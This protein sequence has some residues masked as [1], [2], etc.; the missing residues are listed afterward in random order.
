MINTRIQGTVTINNRKG[1]KIF[2]WDF[3]MT[4]LWK[5]TVKQSEE[6]GKGK[7]ECIDINVTDEDFDVSIFFVSISLFIL[8]YFNQIYVT[9]ENETSA[10]AILR[11]TLKEK[12]FKVIKENVKKM[13]DELKSTFGDMK[14]FEETKKDSQ[15]KPKEEPVS[16]VMTTTDGKKLDVSS[17]TTKVSFNTPSSVLYDVFT[18]PNKVSGFTGSQAKISNVV[19]SEFELFG[20]SVK[21]IQETLEEGKKIVQKWRFTTWP[22]NHY[23]IVEMNFEDEGDKC[24]LTLSQRDIPSF[25]FERTKQGWETFFWQ[26]ISG[27]FGWRY[28][29]KK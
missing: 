10:N 8:L 4:L 15:E 13:T 3:N 27:I 7:I 18:D 24:I 19:G 16:K 5:G 9:Q 23:S 25:D 1:K 17:F 2:I 6:T 29:I 11:Q 14:N 12:A 22:E 26:R 21:G 20:G 28:K